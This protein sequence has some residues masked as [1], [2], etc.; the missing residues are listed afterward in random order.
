MSTNALIYMG[1]GLRLTPGDEHCLTVRNP[2]RLCLFAS[3]RL[4]RALCRNARHWEMAETARVDS[5][6]SVGTE[7]LEKS[8][9][10]GAFSGCSSLGDGEEEPP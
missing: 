6:W 2:G 4:E 8:T 1:M 10:A 9:L 3:P 7:H 5:L